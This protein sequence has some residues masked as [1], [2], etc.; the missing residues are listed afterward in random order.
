VSQGL[1]YASLSPGKPAPHLPVAD[2]ARALQLIGDD[3]EL[4]NELVI[5][6]LKDEPKH[7]QDIVAALVQGDAETVRKS[8][9]T[10]QGMVGIFMAERALQAAR[11]AET[12]AGQPT[13]AKIVAV[14]EIAMSELRAAI[15]TYQARYTDNSDLCP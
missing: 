1:E 10:L 13:C 2:F 5:Q 4:F 12:H 11:L 7:R 15:I 8:A 3:R 14:L 9:H 6:Y